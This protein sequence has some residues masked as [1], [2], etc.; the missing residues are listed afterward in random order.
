[1][2]VYIIISDF[3]YVCIIIISDLE[4]VC[5]YNTNIRFSLCMYIIIYSLL[6]KQQK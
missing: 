2:Y 1:M 5:I 3:M 4:Y 6:G